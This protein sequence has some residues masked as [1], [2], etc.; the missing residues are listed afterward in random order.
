MVRPIYWFADIFGQDR[1]MAYI[2]FNRITAGGGLAMRSQHLTFQSL[3]L[4]KVLW[5]TM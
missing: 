2:G 4:D 3:S 1:Y 5:S